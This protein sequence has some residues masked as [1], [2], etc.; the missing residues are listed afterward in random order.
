MGQ[1]GFRRMPWLG[2]GL[3][4][5][6]ALGSIG[7]KRSLASRYGRDEP[8]RGDPS[9]PP[10]SLRAA[11]GVSNRYFFHLESSTA[12]DE[13][14]R[15]AGDLITREI[16]FGQE[17]VFTTTNAGL[18]GSRVL[19]ME[20]QGVQF[21]TTVGDKVIVTFNSGHESLDLDNAP[22]VERLQKLIGNRVAFYLTPD[23]KVRRIEGLKEINDRLMDRPARTNGST[24]NVVRG[25]TGA[26]L[27]RFFSAQF[28][29]DIL[30]MS[31][32]PTND[33]RVSDT[34]I[35]TR[36]T[37]AG[38]TG[39]RMT[40]ELTYTFTGW[41]E[42][43]NRHCARLE[44]SG[45]LRP[46]SPRQILRNISGPGQPRPPAESDPDSSNAGPPGANVGGPAIPP[47][48]VPDPTTSSPGEVGEIQGVV[49]FS[50]DL[51]LPVEMVMDQGV[52]LKTVRTRRIQVSRGTNAVLTTNAP[53]VF[54]NATSETITSRSR[55]HVNLKLVD[56]IPIGAPAGR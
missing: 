53:L 27:N 39:A 33:V 52:T 41:Q 30:E 25:L 43:E 28:W 32:L 31:A 1:T 37:T 44:F 19:E 50:P 18:D 16:S 54:T 12:S 17:F 26:V 11:W 2:L 23:N 22:L 14:R 8:V 36:D 24:R 45:T 42:H 3:G 51:R 7:C 29:K 13:P 9:D 56:L 47:P 35:V 34:W 5:V 4:I 21:D 48:N 6:V 40:A 55:Q 15:N 10:V 38:S 20:I 49:W 46:G